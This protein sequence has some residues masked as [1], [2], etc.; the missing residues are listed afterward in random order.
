MVLT[1]KFSGCNR[2]MP[3][4]HFMF[5]HF[6]VTDLFIKQ[7]WLIAIG[8]SVGAK[9]SGNKDF[10]VQIAHFSKDNY[11]PEPTGKRKTLILKRAAVPVPWVSSTVSTN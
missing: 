8:Y 2:N 11:I 7:L 5:D 9:L 3:E 6:P 10:R 1:C 4:S